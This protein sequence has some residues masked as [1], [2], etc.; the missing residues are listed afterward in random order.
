MLLHKGVIIM[1]KI[2]LIIMIIIVMLSFS[3][4]TGVNSQ[5]SNI[6]PSSSSP[7]MFSYLIGN[8]SHTK[9]FAA[10]EGPGVK[11][12]QTMP[13]YFLI[14]VVGATSANITMGNKTLYSGLTNGTPFLIPFFTNDTGSKTITISM[15]HGNTTNGTALTNIYVVNFMTV[16]QFINYVNKKYPSKPVPVLN[17]GF[18]LTIAIVAIIA[19]VPIGFV[20]HKGFNV[21]MYARY[22]IDKFMR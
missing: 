9:G 6:V 11:Q 3:I 12:N 5:S 13:Q 21:L 4:A 20:T 8:T 17:N 7:D 18:I 10:Y 14:S 15:I 2:I 16:T 22:F 1:N 19:I